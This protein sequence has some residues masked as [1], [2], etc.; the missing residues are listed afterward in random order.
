MK[1]F[2]LRSACF[3][4]VGLLSAGT[5]PA[6]K[7]SGPIVVKP[8]YFDISPPLRSIYSS[9]PVRKEQ[10]EVEE[11]E[12]EIRNFQKSFGKKKQQEKSDESVCQRY[13]GK[14][15]P[16]SLLLNFDGTPNVNTAIPPDTY[17]DVGPNHYISMV[18]LSF[19]VFS[20]SGSILLGPMNTSD[21]WNGLPH[22]GNSG[23]GTVMFDDQADRWFITN[24][25]LPNN[26]LPPYYIMIGV[27]QTSDPTGSWYRWEYQMD[28]IPDYPKF[29]I[30][31]NSY[32]MTM[33]RWFSPTNYDGIGAA[34]FNREAMLAGDPTPAMVMFKF[35][36]NTSVFCMLPPDCDGRFP[37]AGTPGYFAYL[38]HDFFIGLYEFNID[39]S[40]PTDATFGN[41]KKINVAPFNTTTQGIPQKGSDVLLDPIAGYLMC[42]LQFRRFVDHQAMVVNH[43]FMIGSHRTAIRWYEMRRTTGNWSLYQQSTYAPD[44]NS[45]WMGSIAMDS[46]G[47]IALGYSVSGY[48]LYPS[49]R[50]TGRMKNDPPGQMTIAEQSIIEG[51]GAQTH[52]ATSYARWGDYSSMTV[53][54][55]NPSVFWY[56]QQYYPETSDMNWHTRVGS[57][58]FAD[59]LSIDAYAESP[60]ICKGQQDQLNVDASGG[61][62]TYSYAWISDPP[63]FTSNLKNPVVSPEIPTHYIV[64]VTSAN[65]TRSDTLLVS[66]TPPASVFAGNDT[67][68][69]RYITEIPLDGNAENYVSV[70]W[71]TSGDGTF[72]DPNALSTTYLTGPND[73]SDSLI[74][75]QLTAY[76]QPP[77]PVVSDH[78]LIR[79]DSCL[80]VPPISPV[81]ALN[82]FPNPSHDQIQIN[83]PPGVLFLEVSD[84]LGKTI[85]SEERSIPDK[86]NVILNL[87][88]KPAGIYSVR[89]ILR[90]RIITGKLVLN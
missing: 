83:L 84:L 40:N 44:T 30:W 27:S 57:F 49:V 25:Y 51:N 60:N 73:R 89:I 64:V 74:D 18:N 26:P 63:G 21:L 75:L 34:A 8:V 85:L 56:T 81:D 7:I 33:N 42:R 24:Y 39:W 32:F 9:L 29:G 62:G 20:K 59:I 38:D 82:I 1:L 88:G 11:A 28:N 41:L 5:S 31:T 48:G 53:D 77:C 22:A 58:S 45:R 37:A 12:T 80:A 43:S 55:S 52:P 71:T 35:V 36:H 69:C 4:L 90:D 66:M 46:A 72:T 61:N 2:L 67:S 86:R 78:K 23:D 13:F 3:C 14:I 54:P 16:D 15:Q 10:A 70:R 47:N 50:F 87:A 6:Q 68:S 79:L 17:G 19:T 65:Q 76:P